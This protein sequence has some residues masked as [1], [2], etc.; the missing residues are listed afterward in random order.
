MANEKH[1]EFLKR[2][3]AD[4]NAWR[5]TYMAQPDLRGAVLTKANLSHAN[6]RGVDLRG[7]TLSKA[8]LAKADLSEAV[9]CN[10]ILNRTIIRDANLTHIDLRHAEVSMADLRRA[11]F[12]SANLSHADLRGARL[13]QANLSQA[14][15]VRTNL[16]GSTLVGA[17]F[18]EARLSETV[19]ADTDLSRTRGLDRCQHLGRSIMD[20]RTLERSQSLPATFLQGCGLSEHLITNLSSFVNRPE[21]FYSCFISYASVDEPF[22]CQLYADLQRHGVPCWFAPEDMAIGAKIWD[23]LA[24]E[25]SQRDKLLLILSTHSIASDWVEDEVTRAFAE[26]RSR[27]QTMVFPIRLDDTVLETDEKWAVKL[28]DDRN[29]GNFQNWRDQDAYQTSIRR[30]LRDLRIPQHGRS[31]RLPTR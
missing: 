31:H 17:D 11:N 18:G 5:Q 28:R 19:F 23:T 24:E 6:L 29:I 8:R 10:A 15:L 7:A 2:G 21:E 22:A 12:Q 20:H 26:E 3:V 13:T 16:L 30:L 27:K 25:I 9:L 14:T 4:W 1:L